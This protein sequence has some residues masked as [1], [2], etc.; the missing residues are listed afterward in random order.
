MAHGVQNRNSRP[1]ERGEG[2][3][4]ASSKKHFSL[5]IFQFCSDS[6]IVT[7]WCVRTPQLPT[8]PL[9]ACLTNNGRLYAKR[10]VPW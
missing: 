6:D 5:S 3:G 2:V 4:T 7:T 10:R 8:M 9:S 1:G